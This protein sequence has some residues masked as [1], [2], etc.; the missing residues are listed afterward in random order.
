MQAACGQLA[1][2]NKPH[3]RDVAQVIGFIVSCFP[4][5]PLGKLHYRGLEHDKIQ[6]LKFSRGNFDASMELS[7]L[8]TSELDWWQADRCQQ[9]RSLTLSP[10]FH[11]IQ[12]DASG[13]GWGAIITGT[14]SSA[15]GLFTQEE[16][17]LHINAKELLALKFALMSFGNQYRDVHLKCLV[18]NMTAVAYIRELGGAHIALFAYI[19]ELGGHTLPCL[20]WHSSGN[21]ALGCR[22]ENLV[23]YCPS[24]RN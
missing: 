9:Y 6:A 1:G 7:S 23:I 14:T 15:G 16:R 3:I 19:R 24:C 10:V 12:S 2:Q 18:D 5:V 4:A 11:T 22:E 17:L 20:Q 13:K 8:A 21:L